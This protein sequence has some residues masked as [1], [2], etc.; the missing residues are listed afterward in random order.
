MICANL[1]DL[2]IT[3]LRNFSPRINADCLACTTLTC[4]PF[5]WTRTLLCRNRRRI[6]GRGVPLTTRSAGPKGGRFT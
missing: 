3:Q 1:D 4:A 5:A 2:R 6:V